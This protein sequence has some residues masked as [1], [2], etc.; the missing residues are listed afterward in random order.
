[1]MRSVLCS[2]QGKSSLI[3]E[4]KNDMVGLMVSS[5]IEFFFPRRLI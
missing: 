3:F 4:K 1:M 2:S 5:K